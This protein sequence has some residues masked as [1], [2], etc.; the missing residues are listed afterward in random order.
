MS[1]KKKA[2]LPDNPEAVSNE[3]YR[4]IVHELQVHQIELEAQNEELRQVQEELNLQ[5]E[6]YFNL[7]D[8]AP[9]SC[10]TV[11]ERGMIIDANITAANMLGAV[12][13]DLVKKP[14]TSFILPED[15]DAYHRFSRLPLSMDTPQLCELRMVKIDGA[16]LWTHVAATALHDIDGSVVR[17][18]MIQDLTS[19]QQAEEALIRSEENFRR[20]LEDSP[21]GVRIV[22]AQGETVYANRAILNIYGYDSLDEMN[23]IPVKNHYTPESYAEH[24]KR[25]RERAG[26]G[27]GPAEYEIDVICKNGEIRHLDVI[28]R[29]ILWNGKEQFQVI[30][31]D[32][33]D[34]R[35]MEDALRSKE[36]ELRIESQQLAE[37]NM[38]LRALLRNREEDRKA[39]E[40]NILD[41]IQQLILPYV[42]EFR[43]LRLNTIQL[44]YLD[45]IDAN[46]Q[47]IV[48]PFLQNISSRFTAFTPREIQ[49]ANLIREGRTNKEIADLIKTAP[50]SVEFHRNNIRKKAGLKGKKMN[51][52]SFLLSLT[53]VLLK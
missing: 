11:S 51:L 47:Q 36:E 27:H 13:G 52:R 33:T 10:F 31:R 42:R 35:H 53:Q 38:A 20:S 29:S 34:R 26:G 41:N 17:H 25:R 22:T 28:R 1:V 4:R 7:Y 46:L 43:K 8:L 6:R 2:R 5:R 44:S 21:L 3:Q 19:R 50:R 30:Y 23:A 37:A 39:I 18:I 12:R 45:I 32:I 24:K 40:K 49:I 14:L 48:N 16:V 15:L 9:V